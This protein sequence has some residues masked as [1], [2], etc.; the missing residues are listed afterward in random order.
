M[1]LI[2][3]LG[4]PGKAYADTRHNIGFRCINKLAKKQGVSFRSG[5][6]SR[7]GEGEIQGHRVA[8]AKPQTFMNLSGKAVKLLMQRYK[9]QLDDILIVHDELDLPPGKVRISRGGGSGGHKGIDSIISCL[10]SRDFPRI[11][12]GIGRPPQ[13]SQD[14][15]DHVL[16]CF[17]GDEKDV[18]ED[19]VNTVT[20][21]VPF[22]LAEGITMAMNKYNSKL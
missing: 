6:K 16:G 8:L 11:R 20:E 19:A 9:I 18:M 12:V 14:A 1:K 21:A 22:L 10:G 7:F 2:V 3:G 4:N 13:S 5:S 17:A 15:V